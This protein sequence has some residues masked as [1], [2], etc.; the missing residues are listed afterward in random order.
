VAAQSVSLGRLDDRQRIGVASLSGRQD[1]LLDLFNGL[2]DPAQRELSVRLLTGVEALEVDRPRRATLDGPGRG[3]QN[4]T[5]WS[6][7]TAARVEAMRAVEVGLVGEVQRRYLTDIP[8]AAG[9]DPADKALPKRTPSTSLAPDLAAAQAQRQLIDRSEERQS[10]RSPDEV[11]SMLTRYRSG[12]ERGR[13]DA[14]DLP[15]AGEQPRP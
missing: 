3:A 12:V 5:A 14:R 11:R 4:L 1:A 10:A 9:P 6:S 2:A 8:E 13:A 7:V 15:D